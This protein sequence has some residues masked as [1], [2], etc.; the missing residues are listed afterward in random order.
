MFRSFSATVTWLLIAQ[1][2]GEVSDREDTTAPATDWQGFDALLRSMHGVVFRRL[3]GEDLKAV[4][5]SAGC[6]QLTGYKPAD[7]LSGRCLLLRDLVHPD[8]RIAL[9]RCIQEAVEEE[10]SYELSYRIITAGD[11]IKWVRERGWLVR[12]DSAGAVFIDGYS[13]DVTEQVKAKKAF[14][15]GQ[16]RLSLALQASRQ[17]LWEDNP[18]TGEEYVSPE[19]AGLFG[20]TPQELLATPDWWEERIHPD[21]R[22]RVLEAYARC[23]RGLEPQFEE[24]YR[25][26]DSKGGWRWVLDFG[27]VTDLDSHGRV[28]RLIGT[29]MDITDRKRAEEA[30]RESEVR[31]RRLFEMES[32]AIILVDVGSGRIVDANPAAC[33]L[34]GYSHDELLSMTY[35]D[36]S[37]EPQDSREAVAQEV[38][39]VPI[40]WN[41]KRDGTTFPVE[42]TARYFDLEGHRMIVAASRDR[43]EQM[44]A[45]EA[46]RHAEERLRQAEKMEAIGQLAGGIAHDFN[47]ILTTILGY[48]ELLLGSGLADPTAVAADL[49]EIQG[50][51]ERAK[52]LTGQ[53]LA[54]SR[55]QPREPRVASLNGLVREF[56]PLLRRTLGED[57][58]LRCS[59]AAEPDLLEIDPSQFAQ[60]LMN[61]VVNA[62]DAVS[63]G[64]EVAIATRT[65]EVQ[66]GDMDL[67]LAAG[68]WLEL[69]VTDT[70][71]GMSEDV[72][73]RV[74]EPFFTTKPADKGTGLGLATVYGIVR[75]S[76]GDIFV[77]SEPG[78]GSRF[79]LYFPRVGG[80]APPFREGRA[81][82]RDVDR[83]AA[84]IEGKEAVLLVEDEPGVRA[85]AARILEE[86]GY[87]VAT[88]SNGVEAQALARNPEVP[89]DLVLTDVVLPGEVQ[90]DMVAEL[91]AEA[92]PG[93]RTL[94]M[95]G[96][97]RNSLIGAGG[98]REG[99]RYLEKPF[100]AETL[101]AKVREAL[102]EA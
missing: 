91:I 31:Y 89:I 35:T 92:R 70:G 102:D 79:R 6:G 9:S 59:L 83:G 38:P 14:R 30:L 72:L 88:A 86:R 55:K 13:V 4:F 90:G 11:E 56:E 99:I 60:A 93:V 48:T 71:V 82:K 7:F 54:F 24:E 67:G 57:I 2:R 43:T 29:V 98:L 20:Y 44:K 21:D 8:D 42:I 78:V 80:F 26:R 77:E 94:F 65:V 3:V 10:R 73:D 5:I 84:K 85:L 46:V 18:V 45:Q 63:A 37:A 69:S 75:Q 27:K 53:I 97:P 64:G 33:K 39:R 101:I 22:A 50:A 12:G 41:R 96:Y 15:E 16:E 19:Y 25:F 1:K 28:T 87:R 100:T 47:N 49:K 66:P 32:D 34:Y 58:A 61:L 76:G 74:F 81:G 51:A 95:S 23:E 36:L 17:G 62:R 40:R 52:A 68:Q